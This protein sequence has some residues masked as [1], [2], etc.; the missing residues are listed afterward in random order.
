MWFWDSLGNELS[1]GLMAFII[2]FALL[3]IFAFFASISDSISD[4]I[5][6]ETARSSAAGSVAEG[7]VRHRQKK[8]N[9][10]RAL[11]FGG[12]HDP[13]L[14]DDS[15]LRMEDITKRLRESLAD[16]YYAG[17]ITSSALTERLNLER[18]EAAELIE[19]LQKKNERLHQQVRALRLA[20]A[21]RTRRR[22]EW[23]TKRTS[24]RNSTRRNTFSEC[25]GCTL[26]RLHNI[27]CAKKNS[28]AD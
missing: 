24:A 20:R 18:Q 8:P 21:A 10:A 27:S 26:V 12:W 7:S 23:S 17:E 2:G 14:L 22:A 5:S 25:Q 13:I 28:D 1:Y 16:A 19:R 11:A 15:N 3:F 9:N 4:E 6:R